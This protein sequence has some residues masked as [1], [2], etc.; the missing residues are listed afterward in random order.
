MIEAWPYRLRKSSFQPG[1]ASVLYQ[2]AVCPIHCA[3]FAQRVGEPPT[4]GTPWRDLHL[5]AVREGFRF[6]RAV[7]LLDQHLHFAFGGIQ[8]LF[9][10]G[11]EPDALFEELE[12]IF[13]ARSPFSS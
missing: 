13:E 12:R 6:Q 2:S 7:A 11:R 8:F 1:F 9:A 10:G 3:L 5:L 4:S